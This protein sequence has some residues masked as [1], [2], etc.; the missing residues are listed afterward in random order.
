MTYAEE[1]P[2]PYLMAASA[3]AWAKDVTDVCGPG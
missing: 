1:A 2:D 3:A